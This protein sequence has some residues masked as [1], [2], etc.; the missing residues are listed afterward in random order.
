M[1]NELF[2]RERAIQLRLAGEAVLAICYTAPNGYR[3][4]RQDFFL[5]GPRPI[6]LRDHPGET[7]SRHKGD[8]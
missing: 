2:D 6:F 4:R 7:E 1:S 5:E 8:I 3:I